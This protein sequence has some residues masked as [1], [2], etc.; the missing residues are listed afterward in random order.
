MSCST[1]ALSIASTRCAKRRMRPAASPTGTFVA[2][3]AWRPTMC[4]AAAIRLARARVGSAASF[5]VSN[6]RVAG[7]ARSSA[8]RAGGRTQPGAGR[9]DVAPRA[10]E[11]ARAIAVAAAPAVVVVD[12]GVEAPDVVALA[13]VD[14]ALRALQPNLLGE[15]VADLGHRQRLVGT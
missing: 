6:G 15:A 3:A 5:A 4:K 14:R 13:A 10:F 11:K 1:A 2:P 12:H 8:R 7:A 9:H